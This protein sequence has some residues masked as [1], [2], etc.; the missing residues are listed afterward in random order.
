LLNEFI[1]SV[2]GGQPRATSSDRAAD[3]NK[4]VAK[5]KTETGDVCHRLKKS[6]RPNFGEKMAFFCSKYCK[7][8][9]VTILKIFSPKN[10]AKKWR[11]CSKC[12]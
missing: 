5:R 2:L 11:F 4:R 7:V 6:F 1:E 12:C 9:D 3:Q 10:L 8:A